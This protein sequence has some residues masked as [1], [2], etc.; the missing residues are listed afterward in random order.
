MR[1]LKLM[2]IAGMRVAAH[3]A[4]ARSYI[5]TGHSGYWWRGGGMDSDVLLPPMKK[6]PIGGLFG[7]LGDRGLRGFGL[8]G[9]RATALDEA[10]TEIL[11]DFLKALGPADDLEQ[12]VALGGGSHHV[13]AEGE[14]GVG[15]TRHQA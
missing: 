6:P 1:R 5:G 13:A 2:R 7:T 8:L 11:A 14:I 4:Q 10:G 15:Q 3:R 9:G 12:G